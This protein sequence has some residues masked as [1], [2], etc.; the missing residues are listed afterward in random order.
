MKANFKISAPVI[1]GLIVLSGI[2][3]YVFFGQQLFSNDLASANS[4]SAAV[5][6]TMNNDAYSS[7]D[8]TVKQG[9]AVK[10]VNESNEDYWPAS[11][12]H[13]DHTIYP[14]FDPRRPVHPGESW[15]FKFDKIGSWRFH[16]HLHYPDITGVINVEPN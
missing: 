14:E 2:G 15:S 8:I 11:N 5:V 3:V 6:V 16:D 9:Q 12:I 10:F 1:L 4:Q 7:T 13:P